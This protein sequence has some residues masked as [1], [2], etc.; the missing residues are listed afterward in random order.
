MAFSFR[1]LGKR[2]LILV[3][4]V[5]IGAFLLACLQPWLPANYFW[6]IGFLSLSFPYLLFLLIVF[7]LFWLFIKPRYTILSIIAIGIGWQQITVLFSLSKKESPIINQDKQLRILSWNIHGFTEQGK[8]NEARKKTGA[9]AIELIKKIDPA[10]I[11]LQEFGQFENEMPGADFE[12]QLK[13]AGY[14]H[15]VFSKDYYRKRLSYST[16]NIILSKFPIISSQRIKY[17]SNQESMLYADIVAFKD[18]IRVVNTHLQSFRFSASEKDHLEKIKEY[19]SP[20]VAVSTSLLAKM[21]RAFR[22]RGAQADQLRAF[23]DTTSYPEV[24]C[25]DMNDVPNSYAYWQIRQGR[26]DAFLEQGFGIGRTYLALAPT[27]RIDYIFSHPKFKINQFVIHRQSLS[28]HL[29]LV[30]DIQLL[31]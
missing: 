9:S 22:N 16:G 13:E 10:I 26:K 25:L 7:G 4:L 14:Q 28:D 20:P 24:L 15:A 29:P 30:A 2:F 17:T 3:H 21:K 18:T 6:F 19:D 23:L 8:S 1:K 11:C 27:L 5:F 12:R 31:P